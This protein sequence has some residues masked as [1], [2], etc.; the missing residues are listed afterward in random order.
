VNELADALFEK[1]TADRKRGAARA[2]SARDF[3]TIDAAVR[4][5]V[6]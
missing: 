5:T 1:W 3:V 2:E 6:N 4:A